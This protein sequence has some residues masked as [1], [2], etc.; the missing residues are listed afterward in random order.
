MRNPEGIKLKYSIE[1]E[2]PEGAFGN[3]GV[4]GLQQLMGSVTGNAVHQLPPASSPPQ[5]PQPHPQLALPPASTVGYAPE[6]SFQPP[7]YNHIVQQP[8]FVERSPVLT[9]R[10]VPGMLMGIFR[11]AAVGAFV[12]VTILVVLN[13][14]KI[15]SFVKTDS[16]LATPAST[17]SVLPTNKAAG[18]APEEFNTNKV[19]KPALSQ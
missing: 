2:V 7:V 3:A 18:S 4:L 9:K 8:D 1:L 17:S 16:E 12:L 11:G 6:R 5:L 14:D 13:K 15:S 10:P 19:F